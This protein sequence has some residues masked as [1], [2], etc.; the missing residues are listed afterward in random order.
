MNLMPAYIPQVD[1]YIDRSA[2]FAKPILTHLRKIIHQAD[3]GI[4]EV[5][6]WGFP[7]FEYKGIL[8]SMAS[9]KAHC[10]FSFWKAAVMIDPHNV[11]SAVGETAMGH[12]GKITS[13][14]DLPADDILLEYVREAVRLNEE[15]VKVPKSPQSAARKVEAPQYLSDALKSNAAAKA[16]FDNFSL[17]NKKEYVEWLEDAKTEATRDK[18]LET[19]I[20][21]MAEGKI[22]N[23]KYVKK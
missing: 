14:G 21:W 8:C 9:F 6:K 10:S 17:S 19:A 7:N 12:F 2:D 16:T 5:I 13:L 20:E 11:L 23:W 1:A 15:G 3:P 22:R 18:R 4:E